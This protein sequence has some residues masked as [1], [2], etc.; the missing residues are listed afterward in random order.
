VHNSGLCVDVH[1]N[2]T[3]N[4]AVI[5]QWPC[6][7]SGPA[8]QEFQFNPVSGGYSELQNQ[9][10]GKDLV[11]QSASTATGAHVIQYTQNGTTNGRASER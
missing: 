4:N 7:S 3:S 11:V 1:G 2:S 9:N 6:K 5:D 8:N 10:S